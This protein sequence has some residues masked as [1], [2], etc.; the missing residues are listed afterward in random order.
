MPTKIHNVIC[1]FDRALRM[2]VF[3]LTPEIIEPGSIDCIDGRST[4]IPASIACSPGSIGCAVGSFAAARERGSGA[5]AP[6]FGCGPGGCG[7]GNMCGG[8]G[9]A[10]AIIVWRCAAG[11]ICGTPCP[12]SDGGTMVCANADCGASPLICC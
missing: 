11:L 3:G 10:A 6:Q 7:G 12:P 2:P 8:G 5:G 1:S 4:G 9:C